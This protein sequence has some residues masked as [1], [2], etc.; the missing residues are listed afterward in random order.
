MQVEFFA[1]Q[2]SF[3]HFLLQLRIDLS[4]FLCAFLDFFLKDLLILLLVF[5]IRHCAE[6]FDD[7]SLII[8]DWGCSC[9]KPAVALIRTAAQSVFRFVGFAGADAFR[10][11]SHG[12]CHI[13]RMKRL[14]PGQVL[15]LLRSLA[16]VAVPSITGEIDGAISAS[17]PDDA[18]NGFRQ[19]AEEN[20]TFLRLLDHCLLRR[21]QP[22]K[23][24][25][26]DGSEEN[27]K[28]RAGRGRDAERGTGDGVREVNR[29]GGSMEPHGPQ[30]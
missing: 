4:Q 17:G 27:Q 22:L 24:R 8:A 29:H 16:A 25:G 5:N 18:R 11:F 6:P 2:I 28:G 30:A 14:F 10:P 13:V 23:H 9:Q 7:V 1:G 19:T 26:C 15:V 12:H 20:F 3:P 21:Q